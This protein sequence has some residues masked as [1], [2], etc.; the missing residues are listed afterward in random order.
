MELFVFNKD[1]RIRV[2][3]AAIRLASVQFHLHGICLI[4]LMCVKSDISQTVTSGITVDHI[5]HKPAGALKEFS[6]P[7]AWLKF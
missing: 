4:M 6:E 2:D 5:R 3:E 1:I 7:G